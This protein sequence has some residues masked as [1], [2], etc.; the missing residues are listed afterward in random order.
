MAYLRRI[1]IRVTTAGVIYPLARLHHGYKR[2][3]VAAHS[4]GDAPTVTVLGGWRNNIQHPLHAPATNETLSVTSCSTPDT[5]R[6][7]WHVQ[8]AGWAQPLRIGRE[9][10][11]V[12]TPLPSPTLWPRSVARH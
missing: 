12:G 2:Y 9:S 11:V 8:T 1:G 10:T 6:Q 3:A 4:E 7:Y 5:L